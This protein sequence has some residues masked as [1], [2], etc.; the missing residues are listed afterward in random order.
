[1]PVFFAFFG[2]RILS[3]PKGKITNELIIMFRELQVCILVKMDVLTVKYRKH[4]VIIMGA[5][6]AGK[7][8]MGCALGDLLLQK[9]FHYQIHPTSGTADGPGHARGDETYKKAVGHYKKV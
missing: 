3:L 6:G 9:S 8:Y 7:T 5:S 4:N 1:M 2:Q